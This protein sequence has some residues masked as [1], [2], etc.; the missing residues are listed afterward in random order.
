MILAIS[1]LLRRYD[2]RISVLRVTI[3]VDEC[4]AF[5]CKFYGFVTRK[6]DI[7]RLSC[8]L[9]TKGALRQSRERRACRF[10]GPRLV[11]AMPFGLPH[12]DART[13]H[14]RHK[15]YGNRII[16]ASVSSDRPVQPRIKMRAVRHFTTS[17]RP[18]RTRHRRAATS[19]RRENQRPT[20]P[21]YS[22]APPHPH[23]SSST[24]AAPPRP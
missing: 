21:S 11:A 2:G 3:K 6:L 12:V 4:T 17:N 18:H 1:R 23:A 8:S 14:P 7:R 13:F 22:N 20:C 24:Q 19:N 9:G 16:Y 5:G 10:S 15:R